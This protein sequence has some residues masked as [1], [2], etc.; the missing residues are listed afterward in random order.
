MLDNFEGALGTPKRFGMVYVQGI[1]PSQL[2]IPTS[3]Y[4]WTA[5]DNAT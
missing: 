4:Y 3:S 5:T 2:R 1:Y